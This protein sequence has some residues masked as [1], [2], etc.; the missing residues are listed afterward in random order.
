[1]KKKNDDNNKISDARKN[2]INNTN[3]TFVYKYF[4]HK[5]K[6]ITI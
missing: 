4:F 5:N 2:N 6:I 1:M 3:L